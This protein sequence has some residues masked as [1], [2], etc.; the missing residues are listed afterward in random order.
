VGPEVILA[1]DVLPMVD[2]EIRKEQ[3]RTKRQF[4]QEEIAAYRKLLAQPVVAD[5]VLQKL[6]LADARRTINEKAL[7]QIDA[8]LKKHFEEQELPRLMKG[9]KATSR[10]DLEQKLR[11]QGTSLERLR[12]ASIERNMAGQWVN[13]K[14]RDQREITFLD[15]QGYYETHKEEFA[16]PARARWQQLS[17]SFSKHATKRAAWAAIAALGRQLQQGAP[18]EAVAREHSDGPT[19]PQGGLRDW[20]AKGS[21]VSTSL[22]EALFHLPIG[23]LSQILEDDAGFHI[24]RVLERTDP[25]YVPFSQSQDKIRE[26]LEQQRQGELRAKYLAELRKKFPVATIFDESPAAGVSQRPGDTLR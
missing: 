6:V 15:L 3:Q 11:K 2:A 18:F 25:G 13:E 17:V 22:D 9:Y 8:S 7:P 24:V 4:S 16:V 1:A 10:A 23:A 26:V 14:T 12:R 19:A 20:T 21:L 5:L